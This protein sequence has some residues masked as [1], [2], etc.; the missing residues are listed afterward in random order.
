MVAVPGRLL[1]F[2]RDQAKGWDFVGDVPF[3]NAKRADR[4]FRMLS[5]IIRYRQCFATCC[6]GV[7][8]N[9]LEMLYGQ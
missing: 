5:I 2:V 3:V 6:I 4:T 8:S 1:D 9:F 7:L